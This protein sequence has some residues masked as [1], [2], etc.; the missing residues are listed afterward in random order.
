MWDSNAHFNEELLLPMPF[1]NLDSGLKYPIRNNNNILDE[2][3]GGIDVK[4]PINIERKID[5]DTE[6]RDYTISDNIGKRFYRSPRYLSF[7]DFQKYDLAKVK[8]DYWRQRSSGASAVAGRSLIPKIYVENQAFDRVFGGGSV[9]IRPQGSFELIF[10]GQFNKNENPLANER[11][12]KRGGFDFDERIQL[13]VVGNIGDKLKV[14]TNYNTESQFDFEN[15]VK[16]D[17]TGYE[18]EIIKKIEAG[19]VSLPLSS[20]LITGSQALFGI[21]TQLQFGRLKITSVLSQQK[22]ETKEITINSGSQTNEF[23]IQAD[24]YEAN[25]HYFLAHFFRDNYDQALQSLPAVATGIVVN[26]VEVWITNKSNITSEARNVVGFIDLG[27]NSRIYNTTK[28]H[29]GASFGSNNFIVNPSSDTTNGR[30]ASN[31]LLF[32]LPAGSRSAS[33]NSIEVHFSTSGA[34]DNF[35]NI[36]NARKLTDREFNFNTQLGYISLNQA[37]NQ[38]E[39]LAVAFRYTYNGKEYQVGEFSTDRPNDQSTPEVLFLKLLKNE[40]IK[41]TLP[42][43]DLMMKNIYSLGA[44][45]ISSDNFKLDIFRLDESTGIEKQLLSEGKSTGKLYLQLTNLD[46]LNAR[47]EALPDGVFDFI[48]NITIDPQNGRIYIPYKEP[49]GNNL[50]DK[51]DTINEKALIKKYVYQQLYDSTKAIALQFTELNKY[52]L[53]GTYRGSSSSEFSLNAINVPQG[54]VVVSAGTQILQEGVDYTVDYNIG[55]VKIVNEGILN[56]GQ[57]IK[58]KLESNQLFAIQSKTFFGSRFDYRL[59]KKTNLGATIVRLSERPLTQKVNLG[60]EPIKNTMYGFDGNYTSESRLLTRIVDHI[61]FINT[62]EKSTISISGEFAQ[63][64]PGHA[65]ALN[66]PTNKKGISYIDDFEGSKSVIDLKNSFSWYISGTPQHFTESSLTNDINYGKNRARLSFYNIDPIFYSKTSTT[67]PSH[68]KKDKEQLSNHYVRQV[69]EQEVFPNKQVGTGTTNIL[70]PFDLYFNPNIRGPYNFDVTDIS[71]SGRLSNPN[72]RWGGIMRRLESNDFEALNVEFIEFWLL[73][74]F[75]YNKDPNAGGDLYFNLGNISEDVLKDGRKSLENGLPAD[76][77][78]TKVDTT[79]WG[80]VPRLQP[81]TQSFDNTQ[82][83]RKLQDVGL[84]G[85][86]TA[87]EQSYHKTQFLDPLATNFGSNS[88][89]YRLALQDPSSDDYHYYRGDDLDN[90]QASILE[91]YARYNNTES[92]SK[93]TEQ[94]LAETNLETTAATPTPDG[95]DYN[96]DNN[97]TR[98]D[99]YFEYQVSIRPND[100]VVGA[101]GGYITDKV[102]ATSVLANGKTETVTWYQFKIPITSPKKV[103]IGSIQDFK[104]IR[105]IRMYMTDFKDSTVLRF[106]RLQLD[107]SEWRKNDTRNSKISLYD[108]TST[109]DNSTLN[110]TTVNVEENGNRTP[111]KYVLP[112]GIEQ[113]RSY[114]NIRGVTFLNEQSLSVQ[115]CGLNDGSSRAAFKNVNLDFRSYKRLEMFIHGEAPTGIQNGDMRA[116]IRLGTDYNSNYY[117]YEIP[118]ELTPSGS[119]SAEAIWP[120]SNKLEI[121]FSILQQAKQERND[122]K[123]SIIYP[124][125]YNDGKNSVYVKGQPDLSKVRVIMLGVRNPAGDAYTGGDCIEVWF[126]ELRMSEFDENGGW[127]A[128]GRVNAKLADFADV[129]VSASKSTFGFGS[130]DKKVSERQKFDNQ[131]LDIT[132]GVELGKFFPEKSG[133]SLPMY[134]S[135]SHAKSTPQ[136]SPESPDI[137]LESALSNKSSEDKKNKLAEYVDVTERKGINFSNV[138]KDKKSGGEPRFYDV[139]NWNATYAFTQSVRHNF[140]TQYDS[141]RTHKATLGYAFNSQPT[142]FKPFDKLIK[143]KNMRLVKDF[144]FNLRPY[145]YSFR[146]DVDRMYG[147]TKLRPLDSTATKE[148]FNKSFRITR[149]YGLKW[150]LSRALKFDFSATNFSVVDEPDGRIDSTYKR[151]ELLKNIKSLGRNINYTQTANL[152]YT[153]PINKIP[154]FDFVNANAKYTARYEWRADPL[155]GRRVSGADS[156]GKIQLGNTISNTR[157]ISISP[158]LN[159]A[160]LYAR[161]TYLRNLNSNAAPQ[162]PKKPVVPGIDKLKKAADSLKA[163]KDAKEEEEKKKFDIVKTMA[164]LLISIKTIN[165]TYSQANGIVLPGYLG[166]SEILGM[167]LNSGYAPG[168]RFLAGSQDTARL[169]SDLLKNNLLTKELRFNGLLT[170]SDR[171]ELTI[172]ANV[173]PLPDLRIELN[174]NRTISF[175][176]TELFKFDTATNRFDTYNKTANGNFTMSFL[177]IRTSFDKLSKTGESDVFKEFMGNRITVSK[178]LDAN[179]PNSTH[180]KRVDQPN[181]YEGYSRLQQDVLIPSFL[182]AYSGKNINNYNY[183]MFPSTPAPNYRVTYSGLTRVPTVAKYLATLTVTHGYKST[184]SVNSFQRLMAYRSDADGNVISKSSSGDFLPEYQ[185][186]QVNIA[187][188]FMP[189]L[190]FDARLKNNMTVAIDYKKSKTVNLS[191]S[192]GQVSEQRD[193]QMSFEIGY[194]ASDLKIPIKIRKEQFTLKNNAT[195]KCAISIGDMKSV[196]HNIDVSNGS[197]IVGGNYSLRVNPSIAYV[198]NQRLNIR[199]FYDRRV[200]KPYTSQSFKTANTNVGVSLSFTIGN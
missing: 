137:E 145:D 151:T 78:N 53:K 81:V 115:A 37:L 131:Q 93:T 45:G 154:Y 2:H 122:S 7:E 121:P 58:I 184:Y 128:L 59:N 31:D 162:K 73:D 98:A 12:R 129:S 3:Q 29:G 138:H 163:K 114:G 97:S 20:S 62:K 181:Y 18:D 126:N 140:Q 153:L 116:F 89:A 194:I 61:P 127:A 125:L 175:T 6:N 32:N 173:E 107:R 35:A 80:K 102:T 94:S 68:I 149:N 166:N 132:T 185:A 177:S 52:F 142:N 71:P 117:E 111:I 50:K 168:W 157:T 56:S 124:F 178:S 34:R 54:S 147:V 174:A 180:K 160:T 146:T 192:N 44:Y 155:A 103:A 23:R 88:E 76:G 106:A 43:W 25:K 11:A 27:E 101:P 134:V 60:D 38:D 119:S 136:F 193:N 40:T 77:D 1:P 82:E 16:L 100:M 172:R 69:I 86:S 105:F 28:V 67:T 4:D 57:Q 96:R 74:P 141:L 47:Q 158:S 123:A 83:A 87:E 15:Q 143:S 110:V 49:F 39:M 169:K 109:V 199:L 14:T 46:N 161:F 17:Y 197:Q 13:N 9:D 139:A 92:N 8:S 189:L 170:T 182:A 108:T 164:R 133:L 75:I 21:K 70:T 51:F 41:T 167:D 36:S 19:N 65:R 188:Q 63:L 22:S 159:M 24:N 176:N 148:N 48:E 191:L 64:V 187:E 190:G 135:Y 42:S 183:S 5:Y 26:K 99:E 150:D 33:S 72:K 156:I 95:E 186:Q 144:N 130:I 113:E 55:R 200:V 195:F 179:N 90:G 30:L 85:L 171:R 66:T 198:V 112:P 120:A 152:T 91:R 10:Q 118:L 79:V 165:T 196:I 84:D 104:S